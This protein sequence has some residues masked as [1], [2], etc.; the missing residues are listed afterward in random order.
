MFAEYGL[1]IRIRKEAQ[2][3]KR[4]CADRKNSGSDDPPAL[5]FEAS[6]ENSVDVPLFFI[7]DPQGF[8]FRLSR[9]KCTA[10]PTPKVGKHADFPAG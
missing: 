4:L 5:A 9:H 10:R 3:D 6:S 2:S 7:L 8:F 1:K